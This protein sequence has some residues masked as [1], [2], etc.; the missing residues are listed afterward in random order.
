[1]PVVHD[2]DPIAGAKETGAPM[3]TTTKTRAAPIARASILPAL[4]SFSLF[5]VAWG[6]TFSWN[7][8]A[9]AGGVFLFAIIIIR[10]FTDERIDFYG[11]GEKD[12]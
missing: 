6:I 9:I 10:S 1:M 8:L 4:L 12:E 3:E 5:I 2:I 7:W 11:E